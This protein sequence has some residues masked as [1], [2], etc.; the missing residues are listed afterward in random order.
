M[1]LDALIETGLFVS[2][3]FRKKDGNVSHVHGRTGVTKYCHDKQQLKD[4]KY[5][6]IYDLKRGYRKINRLN[7]L[8]I[9][10]ENLIIKRREA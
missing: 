9:N 10:G 4:D 2:V 1:K 3:T 8:A 5:I 6:L 7:I